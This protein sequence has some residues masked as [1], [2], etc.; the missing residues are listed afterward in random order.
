VAAR[1]L[2]IDD[3][4]ANRQLMTFLLNGYGYTPLQAV[5]GEQGIEVA[6]RELPDLILCDLRMPTLDGYGV[7]RQLKSDPVLRLIPVIAATAGSME[8][9]CEA[10]LA[11]GFDGYLEKSFEPERFIR[12]VEAFLRADLRAPQK[13]DG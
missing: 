10:L 13:D 3:V 5:N 12:Q 2:I 4:A 8:D 6:Q 1:I 9:D 11:A 7:L